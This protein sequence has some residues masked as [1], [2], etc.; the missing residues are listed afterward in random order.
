M[1]FLLVYGR[2]DHMLMP[3][4]PVMSVGLGL[5]IGRLHD[6]RALYED[7]VSGF[8][9]RAAPAAVFCLLTYPIAT[10]TYQNANAFILGEGISKAPWEDAEDVSR[11]VNSNVDENDLVLTHSYLAQFTK[12]RT[13]VIAQALAYEGKGIA[14]YP[15][16]LP[17]RR[18]YFNTSVDNAKYVVMPDGLIGDFENLGYNEFA[19]KLGK[20][21][22]VYESKGDMRYKVYRN[23]LK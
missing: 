2:A 19:D 13:S 3:L 1:L 12:A 16:N 10:L 7:A 8:A 4:Y 14:Y 20:L 9:G 5:F 11:F 21:E 23:P 17:V 22:L 6:S 18:F 15:P